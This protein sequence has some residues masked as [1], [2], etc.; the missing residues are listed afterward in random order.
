MPTVICI[1]TGA[2]RNR[3]IENRNALVE[4]HMH[5]VPDIAGR[6]HGHLPPSFDLEDL[7]SEGHVGLIQAATRYRP[8]AHNRTPF[9][10]FARKRIRGAIVDSL[11]RRRYT[12]STHKPLPLEFENSHRQSLPNSAP[13]SLDE[14]I[15]LG[16]LAR[17]MTWLTPA[18]R[19]VLLNY[20]SSTM[21]RR[22]QVAYK[23][24]K[25]VIEIHPKALERLRLEFRRAA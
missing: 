12:D 5:L 25:A 7:I 16:R 22:N 3:F 13:A 10:A 9:S 15:A 18:Q 17:A 19:E 21:T 8:S 4:N 2:H 23:R 20:Y 1:E 11:R 24:R 14:T 6:I